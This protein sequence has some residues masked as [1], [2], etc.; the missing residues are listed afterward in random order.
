MRHALLTGEIIVF[1][2][3]LIPGF[4][5]TRLAACVGPEAA[6]DIYRAM[7]KD[8]DVNL[9]NH[10]DRLIPFVTTRKAGAGDLFWPNALVQRGDDLGR[11]M[12]NAFEDRFNSGVPAA[13]LIGS[14]IPHIDDEL[15]D[16]YL[17]RLETNDTVIGP[18]NDGGY[19]LI[20]F[21]AKGF[22]NALL[23]GIPWS[24]GKVL[25]QTLQKAK[26]AGRKVWLGPALTDIDTLDDLESVIEDY[27][28]SGKINHLLA[29]WHRVRQNES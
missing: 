29:A 1:H 6:L 18:S 5:K 11:R 16:R 14:D 15:I 19:Y 9:V 10:S 28:R 20:G 13:V 25:D 27:D 8:I 12:A 23:E 24:T 2:K 4:V 21:T 17:H 26:T 7:L 22:Q 3:P